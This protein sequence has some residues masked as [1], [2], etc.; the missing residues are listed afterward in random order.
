MI[1]KYEKCE[2][3]KHFNTH[4]PVWYPYT[5]M[6]NIG[7]YNYCQGFNTCEKD[8]YFEPKDN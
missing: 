2:Q 8:R 3:C 6:C 7:K 4:P 1:N 5:V